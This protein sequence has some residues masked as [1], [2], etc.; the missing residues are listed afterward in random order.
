MFP[1]AG[2][3]EFELGLETVQQ[4][5]LKLWF[6]ICPCPKDVNSAAVAFGDDR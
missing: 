2:F 3:N 1:G 5:I 6:R 4:R